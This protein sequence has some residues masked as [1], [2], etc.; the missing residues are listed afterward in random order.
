LVAGAAGLIGSHLRGRQLNEGSEVVGI[1][2]YANFHPRAERV[3]TISAA[4]ARPGFARIEADLIDQAGV[5]IDSSTQSSFCAPRLS[6]E[7]DDHVM[8]PRR[9]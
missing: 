1:D 6:V 8:L 9:S 2:T 7:G 3:A 5:G 4:R